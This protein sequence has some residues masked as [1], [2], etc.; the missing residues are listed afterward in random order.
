MAAGYQTEEF[1]KK[2]TTY[3]A[4]AAAADKPPH[5]YRPVHCK[6]PG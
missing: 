4:D 2:G 6:D 5:C 3:Y 1:E